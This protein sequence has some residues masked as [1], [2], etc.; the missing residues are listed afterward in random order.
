MFGLLSWLGTHK[1]TTHHILVILLGKGSL[2]WT[3]P[4]FTFTTQASALRS[5]EYA[6]V[7]ANWALGEYWKL[8]KLFTDLL[9]TAARNMRSHPALA[10]YMSRETLG[11]GFL[12]I[13]NEVQFSKC[14]FLQLA[15]MGHRDIRRTGQSLL[16][17]VATRVQVDTVTE[18]YRYMVRQHRDV[19]E[20]WVGILMEWLRGSGLRNLCS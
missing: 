16:D 9:K 18:R 6:A 20:V 11:Q 3:I 15:A 19:T 12:R 10:L 7:W 5:I 4:S 14:T 17:H 1:F 2:T 8:N 13:S